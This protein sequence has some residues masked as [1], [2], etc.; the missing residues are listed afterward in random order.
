MSS[1]E[2]FV[3]R[4]LERQQRAARSQGHYPTVASIKRSSKKSAEPAAAELQE[5]KTDLDDSHLGSLKWKNQPGIAS[6]D[7]YNPQQGPKKLETV[8][9]RMVVA[10]GWKTNLSLAALGDNWADVIGTENTQ[11]CWV[12]SFDKKR[13]LCV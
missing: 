12:E 8:M 4:A 3:L 10:H 1:A 2:E 5:P 11:H 7:L 6:A 13:V 9:E